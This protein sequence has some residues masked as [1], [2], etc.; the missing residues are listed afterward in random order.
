MQPMVYDQL[1]TVQQRTGNRSVN[2]APRNTYRTRDGK[3][4]AISTSA[5]S[6]AE[7]VLHL[8]G[9]PEVVDE[10]W[11]ASG[12]EPRRARR[13]ARRVRRRLDRRA[14]PATRS[15]TAFEKAQAAVAPI[16]DIADVFSDPQYAALDTITTVEDPELGPVRMQNVLY[17]LS[18]TPG[19][20]RW[21]GRPHGADTREVLS[22]LLGLSDDELA[23]PSR[24]HGIV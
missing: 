6:I 20:I 4:V 7:R 23:A 22:E 9:H 24:P 15:S 3:W 21:T 8:V 13:R 10:P 14:R 11:F 18:D 1:G 12:A 5:Q 16:Y 2:N 19:R 17:R